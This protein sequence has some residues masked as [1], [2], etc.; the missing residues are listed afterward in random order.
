MKEQEDRYIDSWFSD[1]F[2]GTEVDAVEANPILII[3]FNGRS[4]L[5]ALLSKC[6]IKSTI[7]RTFL[8]EIIIAILNN[9]L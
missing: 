6:L 4:Y 3:L 2:I 1:T 9:S 7:Q 5:R 8:E